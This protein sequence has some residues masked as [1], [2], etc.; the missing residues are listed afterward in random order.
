M[1]DELLP[2]LKSHWGLVAILV[3]ASIAAVAAWRRAVVW[4]DAPRI[5]PTRADGAE[6]VLASPETL[7]FRLIHLVRVTLLAG[8][9]VFVPSRI[10]IDGLGEIASGVQGFLIL[11]CA[12]LALW[13]A[14]HA[15]VVAIRL[16]APSVGLR[17]HASRLSP[18]MTIDIEWWIQGDVSWVSTLSAVLVLF[19]EYEPSVGST[20]FRPALREDGSPWQLLLF[21]EAPVE[22]PYGRSTFAIP[23]DFP[24]TSDTHRWNIE[25]TGR[26]SRWPQISVWFEVPVA[27]GA[28]AR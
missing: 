9:G 10:D 23:T 14:G 27:A 12:G 15:V 22:K 3:L 6:L 26:T 5:T 7:R 20:A 4:A 13:A 8:A 24:P 17:L 18:G 25:V 19:E 1:A 2:F 11:A 16:R 21:H 28:T